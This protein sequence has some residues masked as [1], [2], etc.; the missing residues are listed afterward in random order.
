MTKIKCI[1]HKQ[2]LYYTKSLVINIKLKYMFKSVSFN[3][4]TFN[5]YLHK[6]TLISEFVVFIGIP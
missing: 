6:I 4:N 2:C 1:I 5:M 3:I